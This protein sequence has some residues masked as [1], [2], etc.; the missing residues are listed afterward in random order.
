[1]PIKGLMAALQER[2]NDGLD[3]GEICLSMKMDRWIEADRFEIY[4]VDSINKNFSIIRC[5]NLRN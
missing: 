1:M 3:N 5:R 2:D 4:F